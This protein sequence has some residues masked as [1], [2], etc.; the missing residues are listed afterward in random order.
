MNSK[1]DG[2]RHRF[3]NYGVSIP[4]GCGVTGIAVRLDYWLKNSGGTNSVDVEL[5]GD[6]GTTWATAKSDSSEPQSETTV[7]FGAASDLW[8]RAWSTTNVNDANFR[9][10]VTM[11]HGGSGQETY[12][13][14]IPI[15][16]YYGP[17]YLVQMASGGGTTSTF[18]ASFVATPVA[19]HLLVAV[20]GTRTN[21]ALTGPAGWSTA[22]NQSGSAAP[23][24][25]VFYRDRWR[26][27]AD[28]G[29][30]HDGC[31]R[32]RKRDPSLRVRGAHGA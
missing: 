29:H 27:G 21:G 10:R 3:Y 5:S 16:V 7:L 31:V 9:V 1:G 14:W 15:R 20:A 22:L 25:A 18:S 12:L 19:G 6:G 11:H 32:K 4:A 8:S 24:E 28:Y 17:N 26:L 23:N 30:R 2:D 13:D